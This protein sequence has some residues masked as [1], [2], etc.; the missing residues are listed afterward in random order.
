MSMET[1]DGL[2]A[3]ALG[4][5]LRTAWT[6]TTSLQRALHKASQGLVGYNRCALILAQMEVAGIVGRVG[7]DNRREVLAKRH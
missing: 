4:A 6:S 1:T 2:Y 5:V 7:A 3:V